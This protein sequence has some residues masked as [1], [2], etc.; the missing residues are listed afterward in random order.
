MQI[1]GPN[2][3]Q[4]TEIWR[5]ARPSL[6]PLAA[7]GIVLIFAV[8]ILIEKADLRNRLLRLAGPNQLHVMTE[9]L[10]DAGKRVS[11]YLSLQGLVNTCVGIVIGA[12]LYFIGVPNPVLWGIVAGVLRAVPYVGTIMECTRGFPHRPFLSPRFSGWRCA[13]PRG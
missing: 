8:F 5:L 1:I 3:N 2:A 9:A 10:D 4:I 6:A 7:T 12:G 13:A 11:H